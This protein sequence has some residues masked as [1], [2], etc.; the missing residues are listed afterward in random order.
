MAILE[1]LQD[2]DVEWRAHWMIPDEICTDVETSTRPL[3]SGYGELLDMPPTCIENQTYRMKRFVT[4]PMTTLEYD[5]WWG[6]RV[7]D[8]VPLSN[9]ENTR[10]IEEH[11]QVIPSELEIIKK[12][13]EKR[14]SELGKKIE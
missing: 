5:W 9:Q 14:S 7:N 4:N 11:L 6:K 12:D 3:Y 13:F 10:L 1:S 2:E 8:N